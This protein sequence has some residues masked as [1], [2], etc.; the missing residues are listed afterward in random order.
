MTHVTRY[1]LFNGPEQSK[2][3][4]AGGQAGLIQFIMGGGRAIAE[5]Q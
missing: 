4:A 3:E 2:E 1:P 5:V